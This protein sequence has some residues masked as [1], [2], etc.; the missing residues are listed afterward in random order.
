MRVSAIVGLLALVGFVTESEI[1]GESLV[2]LS[3]GALAVWTGLRAVRG[4]A[5][6]DAAGRND[7]V[8]WRPRAADVLAGCFAA[9][10]IFFGC[11]GIGGPLWLLADDL[12]ELRPSSYA[13]VFALF[14]AVAVVAAIATLIAVSRSPDPRL[15]LAVAATALAAVAIPDYYTFDV[16]AD[17]LGLAFA[18]LAVASLVAYARHIVRL[19]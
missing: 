13:R 3:V 7:D 14:L 4:L 1:A 19:G 12:H 10:G 2:L 16:R 11:L 5:S 6:T 9:G 15:W 8:A 17:D 18:A